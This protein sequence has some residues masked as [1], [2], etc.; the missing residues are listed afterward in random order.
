MLQFCGAE[1]FLAGKMALSSEF[2]RETICLC[3]KLGGKLVGKGSFLGARRVLIQE[4]LGDPKKGIVSHFSVV[5]YT[6]S[7]TR[8]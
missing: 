8:Q 1:K 6:N 5:Y 7:I 4:V 2:L 3:S